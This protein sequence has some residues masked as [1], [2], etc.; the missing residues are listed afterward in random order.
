MTRTA[1]TPRTRPRLLAA[2]ILALATAACG[3]DSGG[4]VTPPPTPT[5]PA[6]VATVRLAPDSVDLAYRGTRQFAATTL[7]AAGATLTGRTVSW[8]SSDPSVV[9][10]SAAGMVTA[11]R[12]GTATITATSE[13]R[14]GS[15][16][17]R[18][19]AADLSAVVDSLRQAF[20]LP[21]LGAA[22]VTR[23]GGT[24]ALGVAGVRRW[25]STVPVTP[26]DKWHLGSNAKTMTALLAALAV[27][28]GRLAWDD[29]MTVRYPELA[30]LARAEFAG[31]TVRDLATMRSGIVGNPGF[32]PTG[33]AAQQR[34]AVDAWAVRQAP[35][36]TPGSYFYSNIAYQIL[37]EIA[38]RAWGTGYEQALRER[39][40]T[41]L[42]VTTGG[43]GPTTAAGQTDQPVGHFPAGAAWSACEACDNSWAAGS[44]M[45]HMSLPDWARVMREILRADAGQ[46]DLLSQAEAR[47]LT[48]GVTSIGA[49]QAY[50]Y[51]WLALN[52]GAE[53]VVAHDG[54]NNRNRSRS[55]LFLDSGV[56]YLITTNAGDPAADGGA[57]NRALNATVA[58]LNSFMQ[59][60]R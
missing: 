49:N 36:A 18:A 21:A 25:G 41:P 6:P 31:T 37:G 39:L 48:S 58:R 43:L 28:Q 9:S 34:A 12:P 44:G 4:G 54:S 47:T 19:V 46:S 11:M 1:R 16:R 51:G 20:N 8:E 30:P 33:T 45:V 50:G 40:W 60:G 17:V 3:G 7:D 56:A 13:G 32:T 42:G 24:V 57:P 22:V 38:G 15:A 29:R 26:G 35:A 52:G 23:T 55:Q 10:V 5:G 2:L 53:R 27:K 59:S 14:Q